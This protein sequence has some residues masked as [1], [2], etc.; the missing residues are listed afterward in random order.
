MRHP[1]EAGAAPLGTR[2]GR[3]GTHGGRGGDV[4][5]RVKDVDFPRHPDKGWAAKASTVLKADSAKYLSPPLTKPCTNIIAAYSAK[6]HVH[7]PNTSSPGRSP[8][9]SLPTASIVPA[10]SVPG[11]RFFGVR[12]PVAKRKITT[13]SSRPRILPV[14]LAGWP[15]GTRRSSPG[16]TV[17]RRHGLPE[18]YEQLKRLTR[19]QKIGRDALRGFVQQLAIPD[20]DKQRLLEMTPADYIGNASIQA[21][22][23]EG[24]AIRAMLAIRVVQAEGTARAE[25]TRVSA[26]RVAPPEAASVAAARSP[27]K[28]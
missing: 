23:I 28:A 21:R 20:A 18:P 11:T 27:V 8:R 25:R 13:G 26:R 24:N 10:R 14:L 1:A 15:S 4:R 5:L 16:Q 22:Q 9:T 17:M 6:A 12:S 7:H 3:G 19:G 2:R